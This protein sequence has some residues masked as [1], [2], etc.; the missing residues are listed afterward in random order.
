[1][2]NVSSCA[3]RDYVCLTLTCLLCRMAT[4]VC[5]VHNE[6]VAVRYLKIKDGKK[7]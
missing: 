1:M 7:Q 3:F 5:P 4:D 2:G 6:M